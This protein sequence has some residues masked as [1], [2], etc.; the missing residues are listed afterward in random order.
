MNSPAFVKRTASLYRSMRDRVAEKR[1]KRDRIIRVGRSLLFTL[2]QFRA[3]ILETYGA[4]DKARLCRYC[5]RPLSVLTF[6]PEH[7]T[8]LKRGG[9]LSL[10]N[11]DLEVCLPCN[12][13]K[14]GLKV[15]EFLALLEGLKTFPEAARTDI[16]SRLEISIQ[17][18]GANHFRRAQQQKQIAAPIQPEEDF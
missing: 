16:L 3:A 7:K 6:S 18:A 1:D 12:H 2:E 11:L 9:D 4:E 8:P 5:G 17:L 13:R 14:G 15:D 10:S